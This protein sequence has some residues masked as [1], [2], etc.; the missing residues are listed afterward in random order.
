MRRLFSPLIRGTL[1]LMLAGI[2]FLSSIG[3]ASAYEVHIVQPGETLSQIAQQYGTTVTNL[4]Q[5]NSLR[6]ANFVWYGQRLVIESRGTVANVGESGEGYQLYS[7]RAGDSLTGL[8]RRNGVSVTQLA[9]I[10]GISPLRWLYSGQ[11]LRLPA[12]PAP[13]QAVPAAVSHVGA[14]NTNI[15]D[16]QRYTV[17]P[18]DSLTRLARSHG[19]NISTLLSMNG[20][21]SAK[22][23]YVG[24]VLL[25]PGAPKPAPQPAPSVPVP[26]VP[27]PSVPVPS[28]P[29]PSVPALQPAPSATK[30]Q[31][32]RTHI[33]VH[34]VQ[35]GELLSNI[36]G[37]YGVN[38]A[39]LA[40]LNNLT[41]QSTLEAGQALRIPSENA[42]ELIEGMHPR[43]DQSRYPTSSERWI[44]V[45]LSEQ[46]AIAYE[47][48]EP[49][50]AFVI[51]T[52]VGNT[53]TVTG[54]F[55]IWAKIAMQDMRGGSR[56]AGTYYHLKD[57]QNVQYFHRSYGFHGTYWHSN[58]GI[59][60]SRG[61]VNMTEED[62]K[63]LFD[64]ASPS[65]HNDDWL[66]SNS[67]NQGT[68]V[69]VHE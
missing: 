7:V 48:T 23:I 68:L 54:T 42:L 36:A 45:D 69:M 15:E 63:W 47:G 16:A 33:A 46:M 38:H 6:N 9:Q 4:R 34:S 53:P 20:L 29:A 60:M 21:T 65:V 35:N 22:W 28:V 67:A 37:Q 51:S 55:R 1:A 18:G 13:A 5:L 62:A 27:V 50:K 24:Q 2:G 25:V 57:V 52:G 8:A 64:W 44:E 17:R 26:S 49:V 31:P 14:G 41:L 11:V 32:G 3:N 40:R 43:L 66:F 58:F 19:I 30:M 39:A 12:A 61:C 56:A 10:N 59:P